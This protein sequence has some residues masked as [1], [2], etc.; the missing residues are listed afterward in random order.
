MAGPQDRADGSRAELAL[1]GANQIY[2]QQSVGWEQDVLDLLAR[3]YGA[4]LRTLDF[5]NAHH[6]ARLL[7]NDWADG[8][9]R[10]RIPELIPA[11]V[12]DHLTRSMPFH[13]PGGIPVDVD[14]M[15]APALATTLARGDGWRAARLPYAGRALVI[16]LVLPEPGRTGEVEPWL[17]SGGL[18]DALSAGQRTLLDLRLPRWTFR[19]RAPLNGVLQQLEM[20]TAFDPFE[21]DFGPMTEEDLALYLSAVLHEGSSRS[22]RR[23]LRPR[24]PPR[25]WRP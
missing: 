13:P 3:E 20:R 17:T 19:T 25:W 24:R 18:A 10:H 5:Q 4:G 22:T 15:V 21:A 16:T 23:A 2:G 12:L 6:E 1:A 11:G 7:I 8:R 14:T 9:T